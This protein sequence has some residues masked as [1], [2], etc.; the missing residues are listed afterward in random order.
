MRTSRSFIDTQDLGP[1]VIRAQMDLIRLL[2]IRTAERLPRLLEGASLGMMM[3]RGASRTRVSFEV[4]MTKLGDI[5]AL[6]L[7]RDPSGQKENIA[8][9]A[10]C[11]RPDSGRGGIRA[12]HDTSPDWR[13]TP[14]S[15]SSTA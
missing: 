1:D 7:G 4:A 9:I 13:S 14:S 2:A 10:R 5:I 6:Y 3:L 11:C 12:K 8:D 15:R